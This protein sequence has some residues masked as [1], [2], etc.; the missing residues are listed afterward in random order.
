[1][2]VVFFPS[3]NQHENGTTA[4]AVTSTKLWAGS[5]GYDCWGATILTQ[6]SHNLNERLNIWGIFEQTVSAP[7]HDPQNPCWWIIF[8][9]TWPNF[10]DGTKHGFLQI[11]LCSNPLMAWPK[12]CRAEL[13]ACGSWSKLA[14]MVNGLK[15]GQFCSIRQQV[16]SH[17]MVS[18]VYIICPMFI[19]YPLAKACKDSGTSTVIDIGTLCGPSTPRGI[20]SS[21]VL[22][23]PTTVET[24]SPCGHLTVALKILKSTVGQ[25]G[26]SD[27]KSKCIGWVSICHHPTGH[28]CRIL[29]NFDRDKSSL[30][31]PAPK[32]NHHIPKWLPTTETPKTSQLLLPCTVAE[33]CLAVAQKRPKT[34]GGPQGSVGSL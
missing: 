9:T 3:R 20:W 18:Q 31:I 19:S 26:I 22:L 6:S 32:S 34:Q 33:V 13:M 16:L 5:P 15:I 28:V 11:F 10:P 21:I 1:M 7:G 29:M 30:K 17:T 4:R 25:L 23:T 27:R 8:F 14:P 24:S 12:G 2:A